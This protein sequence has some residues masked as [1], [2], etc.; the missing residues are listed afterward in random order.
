MRFDGRLLLTT[1]RASGVHG[2]GIAIFAIVEAAAALAL[3]ATVAAAI[4][5]LI[6]GAPVPVIPIVAALVLITVAEAAAVVLEKRAEARGALSLRRTL[7]RHILVLDLAAARRWPAGD[8]LGRVLQSTT[9]AASVTTAAIGLLVSLVTSIGGLVALMLIDVWLAVA[10]LAAGPVMLW[11]FRWLTRHVSTNTGDY[12]SAFADLVTRFGDAVGGA[13]TIRATGTAH[14]ETERVL[15][16][17]PSLNA[18][19]MRFWHIQR[20]AV[21]RSGLVMPLLQVMVLALAAQG[22]MAG[23][24]T[25]GELL[26]VQAYFG[27]ASGLFR[28]NV[29][30]SRV[31]RAHKSAERVA[32][33]LAVGAPPS[34]STPLPAGNGTLSLRDVHVTHEGGAILTGIDLDV[35]GGQ[36]VAVVGGPGSGKTTLAEV[37]GGLLRPDAGRVSLDG[38]RLS[39]LRRNDL[40]NAVTYAFERP[41]LLGTTVADAVG[42]A[43]EPASASQITAALRAAAA[44]DFVRRLPRGADTKLDGLR[45]SGGELQRLGLARALWRDARLVVFDDATSSVDTVTE[46]RITT[47]LNDALHTRTRLVVAH[48]LSTAATADLVVWLD[49]GRVRALAPHEVLLRD[50]GYCAVFTAP[51]LADGS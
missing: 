24:I 35:P 36:T 20:T 17:V 19:G 30:L 49:S 44:E 23:R 12:Q 32:E 4:D 25:V 34:G 16:V 40:R 1:M 38:V 26:A 45:L 39:A 6:S 9:A 48:R 43:D 13:K 5:A 29:L 42:Y 33:V 51:E 21:W 15:A 46:K 7:L 37:A 31:A 50:P 47:A 41:A 22:V 2:A 11:L 18:A 28:Q 3:P 10:V 8:L 14:R 27:Y